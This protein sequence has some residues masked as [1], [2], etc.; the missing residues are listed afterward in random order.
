MDL[1]SLFTLFCHHQITIC[2]VEIG[3]RET[4]FPFGHVQ[5][6]GGKG[7]ISRFNSGNLAKTPSFLQSENINFGI[8]TKK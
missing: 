3:T 4:L 8:K 2:R 5:E 6:N 1:F 7:I